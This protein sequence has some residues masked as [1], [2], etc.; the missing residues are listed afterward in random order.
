MHTHCCTQ[1][2]IVCVQ[3]PVSTYD[4]R[5]MH[6]MSSHMV[7]YTACVVYRHK[8]YVYID[9]EMHWFCS[10]AASNKKYMAMSLFINT[11]KHMYNVETGVKLFSYVAACPLN[12]ISY[13]MCW[14]VVVNLR[15]KYFILMSIT[16]KP[17]EGEWFY[18][19]C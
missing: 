19:I 3:L 8:R 6:T 18:C 14:T 17:I 7:C 9:N 4:T 15:Q 5:V 13:I 11:W 16:W 10:W 12:H 1:L 2:Y